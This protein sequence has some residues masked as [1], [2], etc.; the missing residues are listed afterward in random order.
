MHEVVGIG[1]ITTSTALILLSPCLTLI[2]LDCGD[3][4]LNLAKRVISDFFGVRTAL[5]VFTSRALSTDAC[6]VEVGVGCS[7]LW[8]VPPPRWRWTSCNRGAR[9]TRRWHRKLCLRAQLLRITVCALSWETLAFPT[10]P[11]A[12]ACVGAP[13]TMQ[14]QRVLD[15]LETQL[16]HFLSAR[17]FLSDDLGRAAG[18]F[19]SLRGLIEELPA[20]DWSGE[21]LLSLASFLHDDT[22]LLWHAS[23]SDPIPGCG[24]VAPPVPLRVQADRIKWKYPPSFDPSPYLDSLLLSAYRDPEVLRKPPELW[25]RIP[26]A[27]LH[28]SKSEL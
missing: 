4:P 15:Q 25:N 8:P 23:P 10:S 9:R 26:P 12:S 5:T 22:P 6:T 18:K 13:T 20:L 17:P 3:R 2:P 16:D 7:D 11:P 28:C 27:K 21:D 19:S 24:G 14:Q 1:R